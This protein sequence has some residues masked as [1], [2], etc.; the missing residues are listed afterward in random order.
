MTVLLPMVRRWAITPLRVARWVTAAT[1]GALAVLAIVEP[2]NDTRMTICPWRQCTGQA[3]PGCGLTRAAAQA[4]RGNA[5]AALSYHPLI[6]F[7]AIQVGAG[8]IA[9]WVWATGRL[10]AWRPA[11]V[12]VVNVVVIVDIAALMG[13]WIVRLVGGT[14]PT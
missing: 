14:L 11:T 2:S 7:V 9:L 3:C 4:L 6:Y 8:L 12:R 10:G 13:V 1:I 5:Q